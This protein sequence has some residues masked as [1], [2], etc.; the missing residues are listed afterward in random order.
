MNGIR[1]MGKI[2]ALGALYCLVCPIISQAADDLVDVPAV[3]AQCDDL[4]ASTGKKYEYGDGRL[5]QIT[6]AVP[7]SETDTTSPNGFHGYFVRFD[8]KK[9]LHFAKMIYIIATNQRFASLQPF[10]ISQH[11][12]FCYTVV[13]KGEQNVF[14]YIAP[15]TMTRTEMQPLE[16]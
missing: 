4:T 11:Y 10:M 8:S 13:D 5:T 7:V 2:G 16:Q 6:E 3:H 9:S 15:E 1:G 12:S 14:I